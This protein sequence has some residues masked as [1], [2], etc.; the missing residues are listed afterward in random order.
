MPVVNIQ[1]RIVIVM[2][3]RKVDFA[4]AGNSFCEHYIMQQG[5]GTYKSFWQ[6]RGGFSFVFVSTRFRVVADEK[7]L[8]KATRSVG[9]IERI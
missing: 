8:Q 6:Q 7:A 2:S 1:S 3:G 4:V 5:G 9:Y